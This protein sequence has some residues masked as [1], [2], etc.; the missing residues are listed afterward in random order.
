MSSLHT[1][2]SNFVDFVKTGVDPRSG[3][4]TL[5]IALPLP[6]ANQLRGPALSISLSFST[7]ASSVNRGY[8]L[9][10]Q[11]GLSHLQ[12]D[13]ASAQL[14]L[15]SGERY[16]IDL[17]NS[18]QVPDG[19]LTLSDCKLA[20]LRLTW[21]ADGSVR[22]DKKSGETEILRPVAPGSPHYVLSQL[23]SQ[24]GHSL[25]FDWLAY[26]DDGFVLQQVR[27]EQ[28]TLLSLDGDSG[29]LDI[30]LNPLTDQAASI[31]LLL[32]NDL[33][34]EIQLPGI[35]NPFAFEYQAL[36]LDG[37]AAQLQLPIRVDGPLGARD[38]VHWASAGDGH[39]LPVGAPLG[40]LPRV[41]WWTHSSG[42]KDVE[43]Q[44][45]YHWVGEHNFL[46]FGSDQAYDWENGQDNL[47]QVESDYQYQVIE[48]LSDAHG[49]VLDRIER[50]W[51]RFHLLLSESHRSGDCEVRTSTRYGVEPS[52]DWAQQ[53]PWCQLPHD[54]STTYIDH[55]RDGLSRTQTTRYRYDDFGNITH[56][57]Y[58]SGLEESSSYY[59]ASGAEGCPADP[60]GMVRQLRK[61]VTKPA[62]PH[63]G[64]QTLSAVYTYTACAAA[65]E[66][67]PDYLVIAVEQLF[68]EPLQVLLE[69][70]S[71]H[72]V[73]AP[74]PTCGRIQKRV[75]TLGDK[76]TTTEFD[77]SL[78]A[79]QVITRTTTLG[80]EADELNRS[81]TR[82]AQSLLTGQTLWQS[83]E[84]GAV[85]RYEYDRI[86]RLLRTL[87]AAD[88][89]YQH[90]QQVRYHL[91]DE[92]AV[93]QQDEPGTP[94]MM[95]EQIEASGR[96]QRQWLDGEGRVLRTLLEDLDH[97]PGVLREV[98]R[99]DYD[100]L[101]R[102]VAYTSLDWLGDGH[103]SPLHLTTTRGFDD[104]G[105]SHL[106]VGPDGVSSHSRHDPIG[107]C[108]EQW[109]SAEELLGA[110]TDQPRQ[111][112]WKRDRAPSSG[113]QRP[114]AAHSETAA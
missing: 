105:Q 74:G 21:Q 2:A 56:V 71:H 53:P 76:A 112:S 66:Q 13:Q 39:Q 93:G 43:L 42:V 19:P 45:H 54:V 95:I 3:Q 79:E 23:R 62:E 87:T 1:Q 26:A 12:F 11:L 8:G 37:S 104:W 70:T 107:Q 68:D 85:C 7:L 24:E 91:G 73:S 89:P 111:C 84:S 38:I 67:A 52:L 9:G 16:A 48:T 50:T 109:Q 114:A 32:S 82:C 101:G 49:R 30:T 108:S 55:A 63:L 47:Y 103:A 64:A 97:A 33:L 86:G 6:P 17:A 41:S 22:V 106:S 75:V 31:T 10:W 46:G 57:R 25:Y 4:F 98:M 69:Q 60:L 28:R 61:K 27:D 94:A 34:S 59:P 102:Q 81:S 88:S 58:P 20:T 29:Q 40:Y 35:S 110:K 99:C 77:Y 92:L 36:S 18:A 14:S 5:A 90:E 15:G 78:T 72:Y 83:G 96:R 113:Q 51:D 65:C 80:F 44:H 100:A